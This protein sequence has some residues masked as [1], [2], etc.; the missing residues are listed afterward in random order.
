LDLIAGAVFFKIARAV[1][2]LDSDFVLSLATG[3][4][5][6]GP[7]GSVPLAKPLVS[8]DCCSRRGRTRGSGRAKLR[9]AI[10][11]SYKRNR[12]RKRCGKEQ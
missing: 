10:S 11:A 5:K 4:P 1:Q 2:V 6:K 8:R 3:E 12:Y 7:F 9:F